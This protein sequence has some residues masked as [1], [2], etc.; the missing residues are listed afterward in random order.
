MVALLNVVQ[1][2][3]QLGTA[4]DAG[5]SALRAPLAE[6]SRQAMRRALTG[7]A[8][9]VNRVGSTSIAIG[10]D[11][12]LD[13]AVQ[14]LDPSAALDPKTF[15]ID[16][17]KGHPWIKEDLANITHATAEKERIDRERGRGPRLSFIN[18]V[19]NNNVTL[20]WTSSEPPKMREGAKMESRHPLMRW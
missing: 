6:A 1:V 15:S 10:S 7:A 8:N 9:T 19:P 3:D 20:P 5:L 13:L 18:P 2:I 12:G 11:A 17:A 4:A 14:R 16:G